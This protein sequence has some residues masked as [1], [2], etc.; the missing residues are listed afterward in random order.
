MS[1][2]KY[3]Q[4]GS[5]IRASKLKEMKVFWEGKPS[6]IPYLLFRA[7]LLNYILLAV[8][9][10]FIVKKMEWRVAVYAGLIICVMYA[11]LKA[12]S[13]RYFITDEGIVFKSLFRTFLMDWSNVP[14]DRKNKIIDQFKCRTYMFAKEYEISYSKN[15]YRTYATMWYIKDYDKMLSALM[16]RRH[17]IEYG[18]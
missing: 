15:A 4:R 9:C 11:I 6:I 5:F 3:R 12:K 10:M 7:D 1:T 2:E 8:V 16:S 13:V 14:W 17:K 18:Y